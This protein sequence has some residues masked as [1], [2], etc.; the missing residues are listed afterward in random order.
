MAIHRFEERLMR[1]VVPP[2]EQWTRASFTLPKKLLSRLDETMALV[3]EGR[4]KPAR[5]SRD[6]LVKV[7]LEWAL[8][9]YAAQRKSK[10]P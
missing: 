5:L 8:D 6:G 2:P 10:K 4:D 7:M 3:N 9:E 1:D